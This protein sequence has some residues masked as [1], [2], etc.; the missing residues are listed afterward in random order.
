MPNV[1]GRSWDFFTNPMWNAGTTNVMARSSL[2]S[3]VR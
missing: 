3:T 1:S 2:P